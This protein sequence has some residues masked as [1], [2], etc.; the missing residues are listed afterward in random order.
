MTGVQTCALPIYLYGNEIV[1]ITVRFIRHQVTESARNSLYEEAGIRHVIQ[2][3]SL[4]TAT[5][6]EVVAEVSA[7][8]KAKPADEYERGYDH[9]YDDA[10][11]EQR[12]RLQAIIKSLEKI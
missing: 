3:K 6:K 5:L 4:F 10:R 12:Q 2:L 1:A 8:R 11:R 7:V 9:G